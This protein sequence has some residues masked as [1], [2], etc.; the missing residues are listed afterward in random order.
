MS[1]ALMTG[2]NSIVKERLEKLIQEYPKHTKGAANYGGYNA[3]IIGKSGRF[4]GR[5]S[6]GATPEKMESGFATAMRVEPP[7]VSNHIEYAIA[8][9]RV[10]GKDEIEKAR[11][12]LENLIGVEPLD[13][14][15]ALE[16]KRI[17]KLLA[18]IGKE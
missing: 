9:E 11:K 3:G 5:I 10:Y 15:E 4:L 17:E 13:A 12:T 18:D 1:A 6:Y 2:Y 16:L 8:L 14:E 7:V